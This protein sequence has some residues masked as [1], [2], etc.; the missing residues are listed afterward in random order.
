MRETI[1]ILIVDNY[2]IVRHG[3]RYMLEQA[4]DMKVVGDCATSVEAFAKIASLR[5]HVVLVDAQ[6]LRMNGVDA[7]DSLVGNGAHCNYTVISL[8]K[9]VDHWIEAV[10]TGTASYFLQDM[11]PEKLVETIRRVYHEMDDVPWIRLDEFTKK[12]T[13]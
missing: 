12:E 7:T 10:E 8:A 11:T 5:P 9:S 6:M 4:E 3:L 1:G 2:C 13:G